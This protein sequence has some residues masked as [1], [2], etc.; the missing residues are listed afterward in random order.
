[1][2]YQ[3]WK[4]IGYTL[5]A[6]AAVLVVLMMYTSSRHSAS[7]QSTSGKTL[8]T[9][10]FERAEL[11]D[12]Y[13]QG[14]PDPGHKAAKWQIQD[15]C[16]LKVPSTDSDRR[17]RVA[18]LYL[19]GSVMVSVPMYCDRQLVGENIH[20]A[21]LWLQTALPER[22]RVEFLATPLTKKGDVKAEI[23][24][25]GLTHQSG[26]ILIMGGWSNQLNIIA[27]QDEHGEDRRRD[28]R[29]VVRERRRSCANQDQTY[30]WAIE[31]LADTVSWYVDGK[32]F[33]TFSDQHPLT[34]RH[35]GF[36]NWEARVAFD[37]LK[38]VE[39]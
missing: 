3:L 33:M 26:Y 4:S 23:F 13:L 11:G 15:F 16:S 29:C 20:N 14:Q 38:I 25:D 18:E 19:G 6:A 5:V 39:I 7:S 2:N 24:G 21:A 10:N 9:D 27:R 37:D 35:F 30:H 34:G 31:R 1:M 8:F 36:N 32:L 22:T 28:N 12:R 17:T